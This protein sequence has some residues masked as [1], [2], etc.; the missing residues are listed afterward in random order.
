MSLLNN[1]LGNERLD[2]AECY[3]AFEGLGK[4]NKGGS[5]T[6]DNGAFQYK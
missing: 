3:D 4:C 5:F 1:G 6:E 2:G